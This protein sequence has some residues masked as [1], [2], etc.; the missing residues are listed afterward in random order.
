M[1]IDLVFD[2][3]RKVGKSVYCTEAGVELS[4]GSFHSGTMFSGTIDLEETDAHELREALEKGYQ[5]VFWVTQR[6]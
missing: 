4:M 2:D 6:T 3:W 5:P 1:K